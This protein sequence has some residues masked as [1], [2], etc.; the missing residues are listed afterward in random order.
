MAP[1]KDYFR[2]TFTIKNSFFYDV[3]S[4]KEKL[5]S[6]SCRISGMRFRMFSIFAESFD[7]D[8]VYVCVNYLNP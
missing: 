1:L 8:D 7:C 3:S 2:I 5:C 6:A 4:W